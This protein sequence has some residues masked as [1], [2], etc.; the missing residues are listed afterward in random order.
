M[1][2]WRYIVPQDVVESKIHRYQRRACIQAP[3]NISWR[4]GQ[5]AQS[6]YKCAH[7]ALHVSAN[8]L[9]LLKQYEDQFRR[10]YK[11]CSQPNAVQ[12]L[13]HNAQPNPH[14]F[15]VGKQHLARVAKE[16]SPPRAEAKA[17]AKEELTRF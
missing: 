12:P 5:R 17:S 9:C 14:N 11:D 8:S 1:Q 15:L 13:A 2:I 3:W 4:L 7:L 16:A 10:S 6:V